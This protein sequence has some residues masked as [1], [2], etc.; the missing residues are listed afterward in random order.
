MWFPGKGRLP[1]LCS[2]QNYTI[3]WYVTNVFD[4]LHSHAHRRSMFARGSFRS[5]AMTRKTSSSRCLCSQVYRLAAVWK[6]VP[7]W[8]GWK[9]LCIEQGGLNTALTCLIIGQAQDCV[10]VLMGFGQPIKVCRR[11][12]HIHHYCAFF[13]Y[14]GAQYNVTPGSRKEQICKTCKQN[15]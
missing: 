6:G 15:G 9:Q 2:F 5:R 4:T 3:V 7:H 12:Y 10:H 8:A 14:S 1:Q 13:F 11:L